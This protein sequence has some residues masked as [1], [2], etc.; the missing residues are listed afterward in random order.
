MGVTLDAP[1]TDIRL[2]VGSAHGQAPLFVHCPF[3]GDSGRPNYAVYADGAHCFRCGATESARAFAL[4]LGLS[5]EQLLDLPAGGVARSRAQRDAAAPDFQQ[6]LE[7]RA[8][9]R[10]Y[11]GLLL[12]PRR[13]RLPYLFD[14]ALGPE[15]IRRWQLGYDGAHYVIPLWR[16]GQLWGFKL[17]RDPELMELDR[18][19]WQ[20]D[21]EQ[22]QHG[23][24]PRYRLQGGAGAFRPNPEGYPQL[25]TE[26][27]LDALVL[28]QYGYDA[29]TA[30]TGVASLTRLRVDPRK[31]L[32]L[33]LDADEAGSEARAALCALYPEAP[34]LRLT[35]KDISEELANVPALSRR[36][37]L[38]RL[39]GGA[40]PR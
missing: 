22:G 27:E 26:G 40:C 23:P 29:L 30:T 33:C 2:L 39:I 5:D 1:L 36:G 4:R 20:L 37:H 28:A 34:V 19:R 32:Y 11:H 35:H 9:A 38:Q 24:Y 15:A 21:P 25:I 18:R 14:R 16:A 31:P 8:R 10:L 17:R 3:H 7:L 12:G 13:D 6:R